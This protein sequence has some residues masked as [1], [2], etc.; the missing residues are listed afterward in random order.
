MAFARA[1]GFPMM[2]P[3]RNFQA[4]RG[5]MVSQSLTTSIDDDWITPA[6]NLL[7]GA[8]EPNHALTVEPTESS[9]RTDLCQQ[10]IAFLGF[11]MTGGQHSY[12]FLFFFQ[13]ANNAFAY[14][15]ALCT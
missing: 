2:K 3:E 7:T 15:A 10:L 12:R 1:H 13:N 11:L 14:E 6:W 9:Y 5:N 4:S 8:M